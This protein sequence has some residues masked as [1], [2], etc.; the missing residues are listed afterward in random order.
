MKKRL[1]PKFRS[2]RFQPS[3]FIRRKRKKTD[4]LHGG[5]TVRWRRMIMYGANSVL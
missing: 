5:L 3:L 2:G 4:L 1:N